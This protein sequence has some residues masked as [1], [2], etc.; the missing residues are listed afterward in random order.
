MTDTN[1]QDNLARWIADGLKH[2]HLTPTE[3]AHLIA[4]NVLRR[5]G[6]R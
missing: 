6:N 1:Q 4:N 2:H 3:A 5:Q